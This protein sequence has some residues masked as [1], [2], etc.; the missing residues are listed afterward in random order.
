MHKSDSPNIPQSLFMSIFSHVNK[1]YVTCKV[2]TLVFHY[3]ALSLS[4]SSSH[5]QNWNE[6]NGMVE[7]TK[8]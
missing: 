4:E 2:V 5:D 6:S 8:S 3:K 7:S 1:Q